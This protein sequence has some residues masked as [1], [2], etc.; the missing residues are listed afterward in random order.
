VGV[1][2]IEAD[3]RQAHPVLG[4]GVDVRIELI[5]RD[6]EVAGD[7][8]VLP[9]SWAGAALN[10]VFVAH[11]AEHAVGNAL[12]IIRRREVDVDGVV[13]PLK[14]GQQGFKIVADECRGFSKAGLGAGIMGKGKAWDAVEAAFQRGSDGAGIDDV[15]AQVRAVV[16]AGEDQ[17]ELDFFKFGETNFDTVCGGAVDGPLCCASGIEVGAAGVNDVVHGQRMTF[18]ALLNLRRCD[19]DLVMWDEGF[20]EGFQSGG[21]DAVVVADEDVHSE[22]TAFRGVTVYFIRAGQGLFWRC[23]SP[24]SLCRRTGRFRGRGGL[25]RSD[26]LQSQNGSGSPRFLC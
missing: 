22:I 16:D 20:G 9:A 11:F 1:V 10:G 6:Q 21:L 8:V 23:C 17:V 15:N 7:P 14:G 5:R 18:S 3:G 4:D 12:I 24:G 19:V 26:L 25:Y 2:E 13:V